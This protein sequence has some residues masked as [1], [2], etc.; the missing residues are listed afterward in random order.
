MIPVS[1]RVGGLFND[2]RIYLRLL[3][4]RISE[5][6]IGTDWE[7]FVVQVE[8]LY[9]YLLGRTEEDH[10]KREIKFQGLNLKLGPP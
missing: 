4:D 3:G 9:R 1:I 8:L 2:A 7:I 6:Q 10:D 5:R